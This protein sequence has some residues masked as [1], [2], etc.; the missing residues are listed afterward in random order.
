[1]KSQRK[2]SIKSISP[3]IQLNYKKIIYNQ[4]LIHNNHK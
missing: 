1:M 3:S 2:D 4:Y